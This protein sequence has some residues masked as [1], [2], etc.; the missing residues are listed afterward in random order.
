[1][2]RSEEC[3]EYCIWLP[4]IVIKPPNTFS[5]DDDGWMDDGKTYVSVDG[6]SNEFDIGDET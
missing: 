6:I 3:G 5:L 2:F 1:M 4:F